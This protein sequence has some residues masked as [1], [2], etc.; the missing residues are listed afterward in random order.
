MRLL[1][2]LLALLSGL[3]LSDVSV[4]AARAEVVGAASGAATA[5]V[6]PVQKACKGE[7]AVQKPTGQTKLAQV[8]PLP[9]LT[10]IRACKI[11]IPDR[12]RE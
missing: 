1:L 6:A 5:T 3:S 9:Q 11:R 4:A 8:Q 2:V 7:I 12:P 10:H